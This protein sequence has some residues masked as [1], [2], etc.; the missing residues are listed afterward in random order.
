MTDE[1]TVVPVFES[2]NSR[3]DVVFVHGLTGDPH[4]TWCTGANG[5]FWPTWL[6]SDLEMISLYTLGYPASLLEKWPN[7]EMD[8]FERAGNVLERFAGIG[9]GRRPI[10]FVAHSLGGILVKII[11]RKSSESR[12]SDWRAVCD[13]TKLVVFLAT[14]HVGESLASVARIIPRSS[15]HVELLA[16]NFGFLEDLNSHYCSL[17][18]DRDDLTTAVYYEKH[19]TKG[20]VVVPRTSANPGISAVKPVPLDKNHINISQ[21]LSKNDTLYL[22]I[23]RHIQRVLPTLTGTPEDTS[24]FT[25][26]DEFS[27]RSTYDRRDLL[28]KLIDAGREHEYDYANPAQN[29]FARSY[30]KTGLLASAREDHE[31]LLAEIEA[32]FVTHVYHPLICQSAEDSEV[33]SALQEQVINPIV[34]RRIGSSPVTSKSVLGG[35]YFLTEQCH[36]RWDKA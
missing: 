19:A 23:R 33:R 1:L 13:S 2:D 15:P 32:R 4:D 30:M 26:T 27:T 16:N 6:E 28:Q 20:I 5:E 11:L 25:L 18:S 36:I 14:P 8:M 7:K 22:G 10:A 34:G 35:L 21:P 9:I 24:Q 12:D 31:N 17:T 29:R 3:L